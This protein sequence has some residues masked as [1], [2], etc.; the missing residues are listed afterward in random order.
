MP[1]QRSRLAEQA[2]GKAGRWS[3]R[4]EARTEKGER[5]QRTLPLPLAG[6]ARG[7]PEPSTAQNPFASSEVEERRNRAAVE[8]TP[9]SADNLVHLNVHIWW[10]TGPTAFRR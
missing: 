7:G 10:I 5:D 8:H 4:S 3:G 9:T 6:G 2:V 1:Q